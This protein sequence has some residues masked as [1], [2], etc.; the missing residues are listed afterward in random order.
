MTLQPARESN[1][2]RYGSGNLTQT[3]PGVWRLRVPAGRHPVTDKPRQMSRTFKGNRRDAEQALRKLQR[4]VESIASVDGAR[5]PFADLLVEWQTHRSPRWSPKQAA[6]VDYQVRKWLVPHLG[7]T[8]VG[9]L[10]ARDVDRFMDTAAGGGLRAKSIRN[11][12]GMISAALTQAEK[13]GYVERNVA[14]QATPPPNDT[15][16]VVPASAEEFRVILDAAEARH[17]ALAAFIFILGTT[18]ARR[19][20]ICGLR[21]VDVDWDA[22]CLTIA[23]SVTRARGQ[24]TVKK[25]KTR[26]SR[27]RIS[28]DPA[29]LAV[30]RIVHERAAALAGEHGAELDPEEFVF[31]GALDGSVPWNPDDVTRQFAT[32][33]RPLGLG[34]LHPHSCRHMAATYQL[35]QGIDITTVSK[36]L[37]HSQVGITVNLYG[38][39][40]EVTDRKAANMMGELLGPTEE[41]P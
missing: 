21:W 20:E 23:R 37:G 4:E 2:R 17:P 29:T 13:W 7:Q 25:P 10:T 39:L 12:H 34:H 26:S 31:P 14:R 32:L 36:R 16:E 33:V 9:R 28:I 19:G 3:R 5:K 15:E 18:G 1:R 27:R 40:L 30:L 35:G 8:P 24:T 6:V 22:G 11:L 41:P 38:H